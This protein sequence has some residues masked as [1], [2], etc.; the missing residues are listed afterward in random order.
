MIQLKKNLNLKIKKT[1][2]TKRLKK[3]DKSRNQKLDGV[4]LKYAKLVSQADEGAVT[5]DIN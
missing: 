5:T 3:Y 1:E 2:I 4:L